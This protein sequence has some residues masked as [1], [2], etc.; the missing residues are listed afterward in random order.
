MRVRGLESQLSE[1][2]YRKPK[3]SPSSRATNTFQLTCNLQLIGSDCPVCWVA[4]DSVI[5]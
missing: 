5:D 2:S 4:K 3:R 1:M